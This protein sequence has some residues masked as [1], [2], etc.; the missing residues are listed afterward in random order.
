[1]VRI[2]LSP[3]LVDFDKPIRITVGNKSLN[4]GGKR[5][6]EPSMEVMLDDVRTRGDRLHPF[7]A[8]VE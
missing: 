2:Y 7:W 8:K 5:Q 1:V 6:L 4:P 3:E